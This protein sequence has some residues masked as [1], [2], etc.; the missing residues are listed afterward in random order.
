MPAAASSW[1]GRLFVA[2]A[3]FALLALPACSVNVK[4]DAQGEGKK[5]DIET[6]VG[7]IHVSKDADV[8]DTGLPVYPGARKRED[9]GHGHE[10]SANVNLSAGVFGL[11]V[12]AV[13]YISDDPPEKLV[14]Y[15]KDQL[16][17]F[18]GV[19]ECHTS[20]HGGDVVANPGGSGSD[21]LKCDG[22]NSGKIVELKAGTKQNQR[23]VSIEPADSGKGSD[24]GLVYVQMRG[25]ETI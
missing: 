17:K 8:A 14:S 7:G 23:I 6:P 1:R 4:K 11:R 3:F 2:V 21:E 9:G 13:H 19:L 16:K 12:I 5:V 18:G 10:G 25:K 20:H 22:D 15:Y 24:F